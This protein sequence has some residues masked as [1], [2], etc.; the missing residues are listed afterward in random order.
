MHYY[1]LKVLRSK[2][3][4]S[5]GFTLIE[6]LVVIVIIGVLAAIAL[7]SFLNQANRARQ[8]EGQTYI[9]SINR[10]QQAFYLETNTFGNLADLG[11]GIPT[12]T[13]NYDYTSVPEGTGLNAVANSTAT[14]VTGTI[15]GYAGKVFLQPVGDSVNSL[16]ILCA[17]TAG[18]PPNLT[19]LSVC[20]ATPSP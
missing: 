17:G 10:G 18:T 15:L 8:A 1:L 14:P 19:G 4:R 9:G 12:T 11:I 2:S 3:V 6:L 5:E 13:E 7:P 20:P 16:S